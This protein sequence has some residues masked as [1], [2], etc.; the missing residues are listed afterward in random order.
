M[1]VRTQF[2]TMFMAGALVS[3]CTQT[4][5]RADAPRLRATGAADTAVGATM[6]TSPAQRANA[7]YVGLRYEG[8]PRGFAHLA[9]SVITPAPADARGEYAFS[10]VR[11]PKGEM[12]WLDSLGASIRAG[13]RARTVRAALVVPPLA[14]DERVFM[15]SCDASGKL[16]PMIV[17][18]V[19]NDSEA[20]KFSK[21]R[22]AWRANLATG[23]FDVIPLDGVVCEDPGS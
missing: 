3:S 18:I 13:D 20:G 8:L 2:L 11:T 15:A 23:R 19:V 17:A 10:Q 6:S 22:Q 1:N 21:I 5:S 7:N 9:G 4:D 14:K 12:I 16:D